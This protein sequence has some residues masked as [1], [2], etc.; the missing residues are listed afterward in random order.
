MAN[1]SPAEHPSPVASHSRLTPRVFRG[2]TGLEQRVHELGGLL[3]A[4]PRPQGGYTVKAN[5]PHDTIDPQLGGE[6]NP[7]PVRYRC[8]CRR[9]TPSQPQKSPAEPPAGPSGVT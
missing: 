4:G 2:I 6:E 7:E 8:L 3:T 9:D 1:G 5:L